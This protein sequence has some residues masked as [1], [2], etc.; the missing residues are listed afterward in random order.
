MAFPFYTG[1]GKVCLTIGRTN[2]NIVLLKNGTVIDKWSWRD[3]PS[4]EEIKAEHFKDRPAVELKP[5]TDEMFVVGENVVPKIIS[6][7][8]PYNEFFL[9]D[10]I[11][12]M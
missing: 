11:G 1:D 5:V 7:K 8:E 3:L 12:E 4:F 10:S 2:P 9:Q 6:S